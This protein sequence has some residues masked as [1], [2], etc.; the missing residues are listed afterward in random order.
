[1]RWRWRRQIHFGAE[2]GLTDNK[3]VEKRHMFSV[4][5][6]DTQKLI[7][8]DNEYVK[9]YMYSRNPQIQETEEDV[10]DNCI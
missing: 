6:V 9:E 4:G 3:K 5:V 2:G 8:N 10:V 1:M 7:N